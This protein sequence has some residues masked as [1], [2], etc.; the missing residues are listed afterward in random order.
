MMGINARKTA[1]MMVRA[2]NV[3]NIIVRSC[4]MSTMKISSLMAKKLN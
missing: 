3:L 1:L 4:R 2:L